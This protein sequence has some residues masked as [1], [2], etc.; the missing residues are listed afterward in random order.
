MTTKSNI[1]AATDQILRPV[2]AAQFLGLGLSTIYRLVKLGMLEP[3]I[4][5]GLR[6]SGW[7]R[8]TLD[9]F[10]RRRESVAV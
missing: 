1:P 5:I 8:S 6:A 10:L 9:E 2:A 7:R 4:K 3:P